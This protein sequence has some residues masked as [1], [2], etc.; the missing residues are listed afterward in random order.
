MSGSCLLAAIAI[1]AIVAAL[2]DL[3]PAAGTE[4]GRDGS[5]RSLAAA[6]RLRRFL[7]RSLRCAALTTILVV[8]LQLSCGDTTSLA[9][10]LEVTQVGLFVLI[11]SIDIEHRR[12]VP[13]PLILLAVLTLAMAAQSNTL[14]NALTGGIAGLVAGSLLYGGGRLYRQA[15][16]RF[17]RTLP[18]FDPF[19]AADALLAGV[20]G[21]YAG[22]PSIVL[23]LLMGVL[24]AGATAVSLLLAGRVTLRSAL[25]LAP[26]L[27]AGALL[28]TRFP[29]T[30]M[31]P[32]VLFG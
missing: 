26:F 6:L 21:L 19:G 3:L 27:L 4:K 15:M 28:A 12:I 16:L 1:G 29:K 18:G 23:A 13:L 7:P 11:A 24:C 5:K 9:G 2:S 8:A 22:W 30:V 10:V 32:A 14:F 31:L 20:C 17:R 25:P